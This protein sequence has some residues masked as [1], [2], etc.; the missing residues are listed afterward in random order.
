MY[1][2]ITKTGEIITSRKLNSLDEAIIFFSKMKN[3]SIELLLKI[4]DVKK[5]V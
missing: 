2:L 1:A 5:M 3:L 4:Y